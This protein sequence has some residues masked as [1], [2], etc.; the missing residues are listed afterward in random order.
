M[1]APENTLPAFDAALRC[2][3]DGIEFDV[4]LTADDQAIV[5]HDSVLGRTTNSSGTVGR[6]LLEDIRKL[7]A[8]SHFSSKFQNTRIPTLEEVFSAFSSKL[9]FNIELKDF[10]FS[11]RIAHS[12]VRLI[13][14][15]AAAERIIVSSFNPI[16]LAHVRSID[17]TIS[18]GLLTLPG[19]AQIALAI[20]LLGAFS[21]MHPFHKDVGENYVRKVHGVSRRVNVW[22]VNTEEDM[23][24]MIDFGV[25]CIITDYPD[26]LAR[27]LK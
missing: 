9:L 22:T 7:D 8:G 15:Y 5:I 23:R 4:Q 10:S 6:M 18:T 14:Q 2:G 1:Q 11:S 27:M 24:L 16:L 3:A 12:V 26:I 17:R 25:D 21:A 19:Y 13:H 20:P